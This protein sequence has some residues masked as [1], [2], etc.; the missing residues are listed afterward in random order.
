MEAIS[1]IRTVTSLGCD[2]NFYRMY[3]A[4]LFP[5]F[6]AS[7][8]AGYFRGVIVGLARSLMF[9]CYAASI[10]YGVVLIINEHLD[11]AIVFK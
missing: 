8:K 4:S 7:R 5:H 1:N 2:V 11:Y 3:K 9:F 6:V 10:Y